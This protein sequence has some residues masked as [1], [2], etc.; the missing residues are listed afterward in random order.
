[1]AEGLSEAEIDQ[2]MELIM[3]GDG[4]GMAGGR[5]NPLQVPAGPEPTQPHAHF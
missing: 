2:E 1:M 3:G 4:G 5:Q